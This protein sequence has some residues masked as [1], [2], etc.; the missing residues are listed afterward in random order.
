MTQ[1]KYKHWFIIIR[2]RHKYL[3]TLDS[4]AMQCMHA[5]P[6]LHRRERHH[7]LTISLCVCAYLCAY[8]PSQPL[9]LYQCSLCVHFNNNNNLV[10]VILFFYAIINWAVNNEGVEGHSIRECYVSFVCCNGQRRTWLPSVSFNINTSNE[11]LAT[12]LSLLLLLLRA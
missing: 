9:S 3:S 2:L 12:F 10:F 6:A 8:R 7:L 11:M 4:S 5:D 1:Q